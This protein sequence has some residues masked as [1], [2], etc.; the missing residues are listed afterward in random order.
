MNLDNLYTEAGFHHVRRSCPLHSHRFQVAP[1]GLPG[2]ATEIQ[3][4]FSPSWDSRV[5]FL[6]WP[7]QSMRA[8]FGAPFVTPNSHLGARTQMLRGELRHGKGGASGGLAPP[9]VG[10]LK[11]GARPE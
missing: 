6:K 1:R 3:R 2:V 8:R 4:G 5:S 7:M 11:T 9:V 10:L